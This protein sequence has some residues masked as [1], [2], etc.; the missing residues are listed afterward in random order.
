MGVL[1]VGRPL[2]WEESLEKLK[3]VR[4]HGVKQFIAHY[5][6]HQ[7]VAKEVFFYGDE[8]EYG[9]FRL[10]REARKPYLSLR[11]A[12]VRELLDDREVEERFGAAEAG[13]CTWHPEYGA[14]MVESTPAEPYSGFTADLRRVETNMRARRARLLAALRED[15]VAPTIVVF[16]L[17][18]VGDSAGLP[19]SEFFGP[20]ANSSMIPDAVINPH[21]R[22]GTLT[23]NIRSRRGSNVDIQIPLYKP[24][25]EERRGSLREAALDEEAEEEEEQEGDGGGGVVVKEAQDQQGEETKEEEQ[26]GTAPPPE[27]ARDGP[28]HGSPPPEEMIKMDAM[29]FGMGCCCLQVTFQCRDVE[30]SRHVYDQMVVLAPIVLAL[31]AATPILAGK[32]SDYDVRWK[33]IEASVDDRTPAERGELTTPEHDKTTAQLAGG[34]KRRI[35]TSRYTGVSS[36]LCPHKQRCDLH[37]AARHY[38]DVE[39]ETDEETEAA[40]RAAGC[41][42][43]LARHVAHLFIRDPLVMFKGMVEELDDATHTDHFENIQSTNWNS[44]RWKPPPSPNPHNIGWR[45]E[46]RTMEVQL[47]DFENAA[48]TVFSVLVLR[49]LLSFD[50]NIY[51]PMS[52]V[53]EN[54][55][56]AHAR[57]AATAD[58]AFWW[59]SHLAYPKKSTDCVAHQHGKDTCSVHSDHDRVEKMSILEILTGKK[60]YYPGLVPLVLAY[61]QHI[62]CDPE[63]ERIVR[64]YLD[65][66]VKRA[67][68]ELITAAKWMRGFVEEHVDYEGDAVVAPSVAYD[69]LQACHDVGVG[70]LYVPD[71]L[72]VEPIAPVVKENA[73][74]VQLKH[75]RLGDDKDQTIQAILERYTARARLLERKAQ[76]TKELAAKKDEVKD[77]E[78]ELQHIFLELEPMNSNN[79]HPRS[80]SGTHSPALSQKGSD[81]GGSG[82]HLNGSHS[83]PVL[84][85]LLVP[86]DTATT[87]SSTHGSQSDLRTLAV[88]H[89]AGGGHANHRG[90]SAGS[91]SSASAAVA[92]PPG[93]HHHHAARTI[94]SH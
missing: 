23:R 21:P 24:T 7:A 48:F 44:V 75:V 35:A 56:T 51:V 5:K 73:Y 11:G 54:M 42:E 79:T 61:L 26:S 22:F 31:T 78:N 57:D 13:K 32:L 2:T 19:A 89:P 91:S 36:Y 20:A 4:E 43:L 18:G 41:D 60:G 9:L 28:A 64:S 30:E 84:H 25:D 16:P 15:E 82:T 76:L 66:I 90:S 52:K 27:E 34:G 87:K 86:V 74:N 65:L 46:L 17:L 45:V 67:S 70:R 47:T 50:L 62:G 93:H 38:N 58:A 3:Y 71:L 68:G 77:L 69:L 40:L 12:E 39:V 14:W 10:D 85:S 37:C 33:V 8:I 88:G 63:T 29:A 59:R 81:H 49:V 92:G 53:H 94:P 55:E 83:A 72:G 80:S 1:T 6:K